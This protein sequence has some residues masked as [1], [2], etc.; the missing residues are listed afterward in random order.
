MP[1]GPYH[2]VTLTYSY[3][4]EEFRSGEYRCAF[5]GDEAAH[6]F[7]RGMKNLQLPARYA[8]YAPNVSALDART[9]N[10]RERQAIRHAD[11]EARK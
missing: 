10:R 9:L 4:V 8:P 5:R 6:C 7:A 11:L 1:N 3:F 2:R